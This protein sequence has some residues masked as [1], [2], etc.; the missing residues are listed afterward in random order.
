MPV[1]NNLRYLKA[2][3]LYEESTREALEAG[4]S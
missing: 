1:A 4:V 2:S 3:E